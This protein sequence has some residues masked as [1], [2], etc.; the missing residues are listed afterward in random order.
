MKTINVFLSLV[1]LLLLSCS[2]NGDQEVQPKVVDEAAVSV[3]GKAADSKYDAARPVQPTMY[4][5]ITSNGQYISSYGGGITF[6][7][8][9]IRETTVDP[10]G[11]TDGEPNGGFTF[12]NPQVGGVVTYNIEGNYFGIL[13]PGGSTVNPDIGEAEAWLEELMDGWLAGGGRIAAGGRTASAPNGGGSGGATPPDGMILI[14]GQV[15]RDHN[16]PTNAA[17]TT[18]DY[19]YT[20]GNPPG[21]N[22]GQTGQC[23]IPMCDITKSGENFKFYV[24]LVE[25]SGVVC[26][27]VVTNG[28]STTYPVTSKSLTYTSNFSTA[29]VV[30]TVV[31]EG[32]TY[33]FNDT[34]NVY[35]L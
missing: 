35:Q 26:N 2:Q 29:T 20:P 30:G 34:M 25:T 8:S 13:V 12:V 9:F 5:V 21:D 33:T 23:T 7:T 10:T 22:G 31:V 19:V 14:S 17:V 32:V 27:V 18:V 4:Q 15:V 16:S 24:T 3:D 6:G 28:G 11:N 1:F